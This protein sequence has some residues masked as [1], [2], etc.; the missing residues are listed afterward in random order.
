MAVVD[1]ER[2]I[3]TGYSI[4]YYSNSERKM[5]INEIFKILDGRTRM[6]YNIG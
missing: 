4:L 5:Q 2:G 1:P 6:I 3:V